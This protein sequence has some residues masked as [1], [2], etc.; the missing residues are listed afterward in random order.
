MQPK[1]LYVESVHRQELRSEYMTST[2]KDGA[3]DQKKEDVVRKGISFEK[4]VLEQLD[5][6]AIGVFRG[7]LSS[8]T[9]VVR[10]TT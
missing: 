4:T 7:Q 10:C 1:V 9:Q 2:Q 3:P 8:S 5:I 6:Y